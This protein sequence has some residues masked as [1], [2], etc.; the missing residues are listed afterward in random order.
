MSVPDNQIVLYHLQSSREDSLLSLGLP[1][2]DIEPVLFITDFT[3]TFLYFTHIL[4]LWP[5]KCL[6]E[7]PFIL[8]HRIS[9]IIPI[10][11]VA[12]NNKELRLKTAR[13]NDGG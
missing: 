5:N 11:Y 2:V 4:H 10:I 7:L 13:H 8:L 12:V 6:Y 9:L 1:K 3:I